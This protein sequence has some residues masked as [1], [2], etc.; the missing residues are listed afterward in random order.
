M[1]KEVVGGVCV[2]CFC[3]VPFAVQ[4]F[5]L[6]SCLLVETQKKVVGNEVITLRSSLVR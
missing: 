1:G 5:F 4:L 6:T 2:C 3:G